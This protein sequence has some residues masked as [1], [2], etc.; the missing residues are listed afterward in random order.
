MHT[1]LHDGLHRGS[2]FVSERSSSSREMLIF[3]SLLFLS[4]PLPSPFLSFILPFSFLHPSLTEMKQRHVQMIALAGTLGTGESSSF[5]LGLVV[6][7]S[8]PLPSIFLS[9]PFPS[10]LFPLAHPSPLSFS[11][12]FLGSGKAI[13]H[14]GPAGA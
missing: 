7:N 8:V 5:L 10:F 1:G 11:G 13:V 3:P 4:P 2:C 6:G 9:F 12:L 14:A